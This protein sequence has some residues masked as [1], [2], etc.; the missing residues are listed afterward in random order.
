M[1]TKLSISK[2]LY[3]QENQN[4]RNYCNKLAMSCKQSMTIHYYS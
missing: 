4:E 1:I 3:G 2:A